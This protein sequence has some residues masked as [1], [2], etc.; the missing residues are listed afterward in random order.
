MDTHTHTRKQDD[1]RGNEWISR[2]PTRTRNRSNGSSASRR[3]R[4]GGKLRSLLCGRR[5]YLF[6]LHS[7]GRRWRRALGAIIAALLLHRRR[8]GRDVR[9]STILLV[10]ANGYRRKLFEAH[11]RSSSQTTILLKAKNA[12]AIKVSL[13]DGGFGRRAS[14]V[15]IAVNGEVDRRRCLL[16]QDTGESLKVS[17]ITVLT[18]SRHANPLVYQLSARRGRRVSR[19]CT[20]LRVAPRTMTR[21]EIHAAQNP[22]RDVQDGTHRG[23]SKGRKISMRTSKRG[24]ARSHVLQPTLSVLDGG[25]REMNH[26]LRQKCK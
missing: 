16:L 2:T 11:A 19:R 20:S 3:W 15:V 7:H 8:R 14:S 26:A 13:P 22:R 17:Y 25:V 9:A 24:K 1:T 23:L 12:V 10:M 21:K 6:L 5:R 4:W 18:F